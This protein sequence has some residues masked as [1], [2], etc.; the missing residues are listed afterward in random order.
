MP[1]KVFALHIDQKGRGAAL[2]AAWG[3][4]NCDVRCYMD[5]DLSTDLVHL[6]QIVEVVYVAIFGSV[7]RE[8]ERL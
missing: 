5:V 2:R 3:E 1:G 7:C 6:S 8:R 4:S